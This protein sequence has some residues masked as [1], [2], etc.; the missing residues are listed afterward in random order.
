MVSQFTVFPDV[1]ASSHG[2]NCAACRPINPSDIFA[3]QGQYAGFQPQLPAVPGL[4][5]VLLIQN[6][7]PYD[8]IN[9]QFSS[10]C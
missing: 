10:P 5:D 6:E 7:L 8:A 3:L 2:K 4:E 1:S 9:S